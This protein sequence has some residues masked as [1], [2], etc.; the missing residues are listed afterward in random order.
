MWTNPRSHLKCPC[1]ISFGRGIVVIS[2]VV[3]VMVVVVSVVV[4]S[5]AIVLVV[6]MSVLVAVEGSF[7]FEFDGGGA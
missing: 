2:A 3:V 7:N 6:V 1:W 5:I 4:V